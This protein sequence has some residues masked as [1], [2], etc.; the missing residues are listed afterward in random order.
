MNSGH[1]NGRLTEHA[2]MT[3]LYAYEAG[4]VGWAD[5]VFGV[6]AMFVAYIHRHVSKA[7]NNWRNFPFFRNFLMTVKTSK[8]GFKP[9]TLH[10][11]SFGLQPNL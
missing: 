10:V 5:E 2:H 8:Q 11:V 6:R 1:T 4:L 7:E 9:A 3:L